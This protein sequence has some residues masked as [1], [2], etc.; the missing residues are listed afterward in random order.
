MGT[1]VFSSCRLGRQLLDGG[2]SPGVLLTG[3]LIR[4]IGFWSDNCA[5]VSIQLLAGR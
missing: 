3:L 2:T 1:L 5:A 4:R